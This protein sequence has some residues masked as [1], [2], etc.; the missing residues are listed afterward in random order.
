MKAS[1]VT[2]VAALAIASTNTAAARFFG[3]DL[4]CKWINYT[5][6]IGHSDDKRSVMMEALCDRSPGHGD[7]H[8]TRLDLTNCL[9]WDIYKCNFV[10]PRG[11]AA[12]FTQWCEACSIGTGSREGYEIHP[13]LDCDCTCWDDDI[14]FGKKGKVSIS[15]SRCMHFSPPPSFTTIRGLE[16][17]TRA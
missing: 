11:I 14:A 3:F 12:P 13:S 5:N 8:S 4:T 6:L 17:L 7:P 15:L 1:T 9:G 2:T 16:L 10:T